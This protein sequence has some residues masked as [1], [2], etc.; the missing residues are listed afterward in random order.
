ML[1][2]FAERAFTCSSAWLSASA[3][4]GVAAAG[5][6]LDEV[7]DAGLGA[8]QLDLLEAQFL[9]DVGEELLHLRGGSF[10][11]LVQF[12]AARITTARAPSAAPKSP[13][14]STAWSRAPSSLA[15]N[16]T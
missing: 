10:V 8:V 4:V 16:R 2:M 12:W 15:S 14:C 1:W 7:V 3:R 5:D 11:D 9:R 6:E 13:P